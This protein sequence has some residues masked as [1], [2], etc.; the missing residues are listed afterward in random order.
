MG[1]YRSVVWLSTWFCK[2][3]SGCRVSLH[4]C[5][6]LEVL[7]PT[8]WLQRFRYLQK[9]GRYLVSHMGVFLRYSGALGGLGV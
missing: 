7:G 1:L 9:R 8:S 6:F 2:G 4:I 3:L 5:Y